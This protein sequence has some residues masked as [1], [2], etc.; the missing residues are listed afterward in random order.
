MQKYFYTLCVL[1]TAFD[2]MAQ[3]LLPLSV[4]QMPDSLRKGAK[5]VYR[6]H[7]T[8]INISS[9]SRYSLNEQ[10]AI[11]IFTKS[12]MEE[13]ATI[14]LPAYK[15]I[16]LDDVEIK[17]YDSL[18]IETG[19]YKKKDFSLIGSPMSDALVSDSKYYYLTIGSSS[20]P[21]TIVVN[22]TIEFYGY[23]DFPDWYAA[24]FDEA[25]EQ[26]TCRVTV[27]QELDIRYKAFNSN[28]QPA[29][30]QNGNLKVYEWKNGQQK[31]LDKEPGSISARSQL[32]RIALA[33]NLF[34]YDDYKGSFK[35]WKDYGQ[36]YYNFYE[37]KE[38][39]N[40]TIEDH[41]KSSVAHLK[42]PKEKIEFL[43]KKMQQETRYVSIQLGIGGL[44]PF[45]ASF[46][47]EKKYGDCKALSNY[48]KHLLKVIGINSYA[49]IIKSGAN[50][51]PADVDFP[52]EGFDHV[53][54]CVPMEKDTIWLECTSKLTPPGIPGNFTENRNA[55]L[56]TEKGGVLVN[57]PRSKSEHNQWISKSNVELFDDGSA[58][59]NSRVYVTGEFY[60]MVN[61][62]LINKSKD[63]YRKALV[64][65]F[66]YKAPDEVE[67]TLLG[68]SANG[69]NIQLQ[70]A[71]NRYFDFQAGKKFFFPV[72]HYKI[73]DED[74][75][76]A[77][78]RNSPYMFQFPYIKKDTMVYHLPATLLPEN[79]TATTKTDNPFSSWN[80]SSQFNE[81]QK[82]LT[83]V[84][85]LSI[86]R[87]IIP[88]E[89]YEQTAAFFQQVKK[90]ENQKLVLKKE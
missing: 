29:I 56:V 36:W 84:T 47:E 19:K 87:H 34:E 81:Q 69:K 70:F 22:S 17:V 89:N 45:P 7:H 6:Y 42:T 8:D 78:K 9:A 24:S 51:S 25:Y 62:L 16:K 83:V 20:L 13:Y 59:I 52:N 14:I 85:A 4:K 37:E 27:P 44:K 58:V 31:L 88:A 35:T 41:I 26:N 23:V 43:Y 18:G 1:F 32:P 61:Y 60:E 64:N 76:P 53:I 71:Y 79:S 10:K 40:K 12:A 66:D 11:T 3:L 73:N 21:I 46:V 68:D 75:K 80:S 57:T 74:L 54:L 39:F 33:P 67:F 63:E 65:I 86:N 48:M 90:E 72:R 55:L 38:P 82:I 77:S 15:H 5:A 49:A 28:I 50:A 30:S 2:G